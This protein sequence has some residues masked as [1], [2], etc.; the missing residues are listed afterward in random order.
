MPGIHGESH[1]LTDRFGYRSDGSPARADLRLLTLGGS[2][3]ECLYLDQTETWPRLL[4]DWLRSRT[5]RTAWVANA[6]KSGLN[7]YHHVVQVERLLAQSPDFDVVVLFVGL[8]DMHQRLRKGGDAVAFDT[9]HRG[10]AIEVEARALAVHPE[11]YRWSGLP[12][13][14]A[15]AALVTD[16][17]RAPGRR[18]SA[19][20]DIRVEDDRGQTYVR[21]REMRSNA[22]VWA[23][24][25]PDLSAAL[26]AYAANLGR[27]L[28]RIRGTGARALVITQ[29]SLW[30]ETIAPEAE[31]LLWFGWFEDE[32]W[33]PK[34]Y[35]TG[36]ALMTAMNRYNS[37]TREVAASRNVPIL[38]L[39]RTMPKSPQYFYDDCHFTEAGAQHGAL[40]IGGAVAETLADLPRARGANKR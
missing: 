34:G 28:D 8:N 17:W 7:T 33:E 11:P 32:P 18:R 37:T 31:R 5:G 35:Y 21:R 9:W 30:E 19:A 36:E 16:A 13:N 15:I 40:V 3:T 24:S 29:P 1:F 4:Q 23:D 25:P 22:E 26:D 39:A 2:T 12:R 20:A 6:G 10:H 14:T 27:V 38:D